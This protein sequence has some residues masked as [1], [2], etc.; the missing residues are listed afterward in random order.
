VPFVE[1]S[2][3]AYTLGMSA[4]LATIIVPAFNEGAEFRAT[5]ARLERFSSS[6]SDRYVLQLLVI[7]DGST[8][9]TPAIADAFARESG[10][11]RVIHHDRNRGIAAGL[12]TGLGEVR[13]GPAVVLDADLSY[14]PEEVVIPMLETL[15]LR[16]AA[17]VVASPYMR[18]G[19]V[20]NVPFV[21]LLAS[22]CAN[23]LL[24]ILTGRR[25]ATLTGM[26]RAYSPA[27]IARALACRPD[28]EFNSWILLDALSS[29]AIVA[30]VPAHLCW[31]P[32][33]LAGAPRMPLQKL[34]R[35]TL[36]VLRTIRFHAR[37]LKNTG[38]SAE[39]AAKGVSI[40]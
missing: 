5:L 30:E 11:V 3:Y 19:R 33:R 37:G 22:R 26:V 24:S 2:R 39:S 40:I 9:E 31:P 25:V 16:Q 17:I 21:R 18:G 13:G 1:F 27:A 12:Q 35:A 36:A 29:G 23:A 32:N 14:A 10:N 15:E 34:A 20:S 8:D 28:G 6:V 4:L 7:D 38:A